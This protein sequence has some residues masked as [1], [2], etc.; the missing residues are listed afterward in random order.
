MSVL[1]LEHLCLDFGSAPI[2][3]KAS[4]VLA[5]AERV[6]LVGRNGAGKSSLMKV[7]AGELLPESGLVIKGPGVK[8]SYLRQ[9]L[10]EPVAK[11][12]F[13]HVAE[14]LGEA[15]Q[16]LSEYEHLSLNL[17]LEPSPAALKRLEWLQHQL[18]E[19]QGWTQRTKVEAML[20]RM[21]L[22]GSKL[23]SELSG[24]WLKRADLARALVQEP[25]LLLLDE[26][27]NHLDVEA[28]EWLERFLLGWSGTL[29]FI[30]HDRTLIEHLATRILEL[31]R[32]VLTSWNTT[33]AEY[34]LQK[35]QQLAV[36][37]RHHQLFDKKLA[38][39]EV[40]IR[41]GIKARRTRNEGRVRALEAMRLE[42]KERLAV[43]GQAK[44]ALSV[45]QNS[46]RQVF[47]LQQVS[48]A[49]GDKVIVQ[50]LDLNL[51]RG[52][53]LGL[54]GANGAGKTSLIRLLL[55]DLEPDSG[56]IKRGTQLEVAYFDQHRFQLDLD[57][58]VID[59]L[60]EGQTELTVNGVR[61][62]A[63]SYL[64]DFLFTSD[65]ARAPAKVL[66]GGER[67][68]LLLARL[69]L[70]PCNLLI[71]DEPTNDLDL[72]TLE[73]LE[74]QLSQ[75]QGTL[76]LVS[77]D[78]KF[79]DAVVTSTLV[80]EGHGRWQEYAGGYSDY[81]YQRQAVPQAK[82]MAAA[83]PAATSPELKASVKAKSKKLSYQLQR[84]LDGLPARL[85][86]IESDCQL[87]EQQL[88]GSEFYLLPALQQQQ[89]F[90]QLARLKA[91][92]EQMLERWLELEQMQ[93]G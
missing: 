53:R 50:G 66:S 73:L 43:Q 65:R 16:W 47:E 39:E 93:Q 90:E 44:M 84:E 75:Y 41:Q 27:T 85:E 31:D 60:A 28:I 21:E 48:L 79:L 62:H 2:L 59:N 86:Q 46:G 1:I 67:N 68:R 70:K 92:Q 6:C 8:V 25:Q 12:L 38:E 37:Q 83:S 61:R 91:E 20:Q 72:D 15:G 81:C 63:I 87:L 88:N 54:V 45:G 56:S 4:A 14:G 11:S 58:T 24:G 80:S 17:G 7:V 33:Y 74:E 29:L 10:P 19:I 52:D 13:E 32:G 36:E 30:S 34:Q 69:F 3:D 42:R 64:N 49:F 35:E 51:M 78:R 77:H 40:W 57:K 23:L 22:D 76:I 89:S 9:Q 71:M 55:G 18:D 82:A 26:P 5:P